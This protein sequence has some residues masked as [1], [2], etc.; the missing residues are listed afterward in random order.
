LL[1]SRFSDVRRDSADACADA[2]RAMS[3]EAA[4]FQQ[5]CRA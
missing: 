3:S 5:V 4:M 2:R 1:D